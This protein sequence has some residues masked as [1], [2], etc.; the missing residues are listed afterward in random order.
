M[1][2]KQ[3]FFKRDFCIFI[4]TLKTITKENLEKTMNKANLRSTNS[5]NLSEVKA[6]KMS[7]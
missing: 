4:K 1:L 7:F 2:P 3:T 6:Y 5:E